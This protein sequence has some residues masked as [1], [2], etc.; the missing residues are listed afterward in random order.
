VKL[1]EILRE[2]EASDAA[3]KKGWKSKGG[4]AWMDKSGK[5]VAIT[6]K[7]KLTPVGSD[8][9]SKLKSVKSQ[10]DPD[11]GDKAVTPKLG[12][13]ASSELNDFSGRAEDW[14][15]VDPTEWKGLDHEEKVD[16]IQHDSALMDALTDKGVDTSIL[17]PD[18]VSKM[19]D[20]I[21]TYYGEEDDR[22]ETEPQQYEKT[23]EKE[24]KKAINTITNAEG[25]DGGSPEDQARIAHDYMTNE[26]IPS[27]KND[28]Y[29]YGEMAAER[30]ASSL[31]SNWRS[32]EAATAVLNAWNDNKV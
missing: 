32:K 10:D 20:N 22:E 29:K 12:D 19:V 28:S 1:R 24:R 26:F 21:D 14:L 27:V 30:L 18:N 31:Y 23:A 5:T 25:F 8:D 16:I 3:H 17:T 13:E 11:F 2:S 15:R 4:G 7:G 9:K 6:K